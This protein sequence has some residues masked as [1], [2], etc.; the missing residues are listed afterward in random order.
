M[1]T[2]TARARDPL[3]ERGKVGLAEAKQTAFGR[4]GLGVGSALKR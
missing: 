4:R 3:G 1:G 2:S